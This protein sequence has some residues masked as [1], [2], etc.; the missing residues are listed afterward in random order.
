MIIT[1]VYSPIGL[2]G[3]VPECLDGPSL[4]PTELHFH[5]PWIEPRLIASSVSHHR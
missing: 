4:V 3:S 5:L 1:L 2:D